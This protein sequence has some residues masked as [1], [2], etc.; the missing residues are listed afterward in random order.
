ML[1]KPIDRITPFGH[2]PHRYQDASSIIA[3]FPFART[4]T[5]AFYAFLMAALQLLLEH[6]VKRLP[7]VDKQ[8][9]LV[10]LLGRGG[11]LQALSH[12]L[13]NESTP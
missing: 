9:R 10:G 6:R 1:F 7:V 12:E 13:R 3:Q 5:L 8:G 4:G 11:V 2:L